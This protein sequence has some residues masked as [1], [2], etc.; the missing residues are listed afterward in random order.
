MAVEGGMMT[1]QTQDHG[2]AP[3]PAMLTVPIADASAWTRAD[4]DLAAVTVP[5]DE[6]CHAPVVAVGTAVDGVAG[7]GAV[8][9]LRPEQFALDHCRA[10]AAQ[11]RHIL[12]AGPRFCL[13]D[14]LP[15]EALGSP[16]AAKAC[17][18]ILASLVSR[19]VAQKRD[20]TLIYDVH[21]TGQQAAPGSGVRPDK[22]NIDLTFHNDNAYNAVMPEVVGL[23][24]LRPAVSGGVSRVMSFQTAHNALLDRHTG[25]LPRLYQSFW[26]DRQR[27]FA[28][29]EEPT[30]AAPIFEFDGRQLGAR[31][32]LH[33]VRNAYAMRGAALDDA[34]ARALAALADVFADESLSFDF[35]MTAG[36]MQFVKNRA[37]GHSRTRFFD[38]HS[39]EQRCRPVPLCMRDCA[40]D[41]YACA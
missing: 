26:H 6:P 28:P 13:V 22:T 20:G 29:G 14:R 3:H 16:E 11:I 32:G 5:L 10:A 24:C 23:L 2:T 35:T 37:T 27:E 25:C 34:G 17:Y 15:L 1:P 38:A 18:W 12:Q 31:L 40:R 33:Q 39:P 41:D 4:I 19:P 9:A 8:Q 36:Q 30:F 7:G 21:D